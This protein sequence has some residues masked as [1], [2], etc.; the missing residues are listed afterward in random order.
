MFQS[1]IIP[2]LLT[3]MVCIV[4]ARMEVRDEDSDSIFRGTREDQ[5]TTTVIVSF[6]GSNLQNIR[7]K[8]KTREFS[9]RTHRIQSLH[10]DLQDYANTI[11]RN[12]LNMLSKHKSASPIEV[13][14]LWMSNQ[15]IVKNA[16][17]T[18]VKTLQNM[19]EVSGVMEDIR[20]TM[21][22]N[23]IQQDYP[24]NNKRTNA[25]PTWGIGAIH[26]PEVWAAGIRGAKVVVADIDSG[27]RGTHEALRDGFREENGW[28]DPIGK[29]PVPKD[30]VGH[31][32][33]TTG[34]IVGRT[35]GIGVAPEAQWIA[36]RG[37]GDDGVCDLSAFMRCGQWALCPTDVNGSNPRCDL[38]PHVISNS[39]GA[40]A[41][42]D[43]FDETLANW[44][45]A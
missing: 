23:F 35:N 21:D 18:L 28:F 41:G 1:T 17:V 3:C 32:T 30:A 42:L 14:Q 45:A 34:T 11:Q 38:A 31:G 2:L 29:S 37:C 26:A 40:G 36:C 7:N 4:V 25:D 9:S 44:V 19:E 39:W 5:K 27:V 10:D 20:F 13:H 12:V 24:T 43:Y 22:E 8:L 33:H 6:K 15:V 16:D